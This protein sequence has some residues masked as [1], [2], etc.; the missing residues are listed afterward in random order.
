[1]RFTLATRFHGCDRRDAAAFDGEQH[2]RPHRHPRMIVVTQSIVAEN[3]TGVLAADDLEITLLEQ[4][5]FI[6]AYL[7]DDGT[8]ASPQT[9][10]D[11]E[12]GTGLGL[13]IAAVS[14]NA[15]AAGWSWKV[16]H[17]GELR[18]PSGSPCMPDKPRSER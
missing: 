4:R 14:W 17:R 7:L 6:T 5:E 11:Q 2:G 18:L 8:E 9:R 12:H 1:M 10:L 15:T 13:C 16:P 3:L